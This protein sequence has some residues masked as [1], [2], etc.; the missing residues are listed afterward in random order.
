VAHC[1]S[2]LARDPGAPLGLW[3]RRTGEPLATRLLTAF[4]S[5]SRR[6]GLLG[7]DGL[8]PGEAL[9]IAPCASVHT[10]FM[11]FPLDLV[12]IDRGGRV[13]RTSLDVKPW[14]IRLALRA[15]AVVEL[16]TGTVLRSDTRCNDVLQ[17][18]TIV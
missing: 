10:A 6:T 9:V 13:V 7:R 15:F 5:R 12:F 3:N 14:R 17:L 1:L 2:A 8:A 16:A 11:R 18:R 4:D